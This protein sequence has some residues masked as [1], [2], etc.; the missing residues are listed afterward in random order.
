MLV[1][2]GV[3]LVCIENGDQTKQI[4]F[5]Y[6]SKKSC[7]TIL[8]LHEVLP[9]YC[10]YHHLRMLFFGLVWNLFQ[11]LN[12]ILKKKQKSSLQ[13]K[14]LEVT[15]WEAL[16]KKNQYLPEKHLSRGLC[17]WAFHWPVRRTWDAVRY[18]ASNARTDLP[19][20]RD[21]PLP[22]QPRLG[23][24]CAFGVP[25]CTSG[26]CER[27]GVGNIGIGIDWAKQMTVTIETAW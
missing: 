19:P 7:D 9:F 1:S 3:W 6:V 5:I 22:I 24:L 4:I 27:K 23:L 26:E 16:K 25:N 18:A 17:V 21:P 8:L 11:V 2:G 15:K 12:S 10:G 13:R 20:T 14:N